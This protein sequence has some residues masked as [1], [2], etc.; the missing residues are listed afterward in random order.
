MTKI[1]SL[2]HYACFSMQS[3]RNFEG[4]E[5]NKICTEGASDRRKEGEGRG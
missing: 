2:P 3:R 1:I 5:R 4:W